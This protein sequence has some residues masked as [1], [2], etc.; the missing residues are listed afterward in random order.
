M[1][2]SGKKVDLVVLNDFLKK[3]IHP[4]KRLKNKAYK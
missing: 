4:F 3:K 2:K 1:T